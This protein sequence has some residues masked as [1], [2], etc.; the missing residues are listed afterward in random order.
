MTGGHPFP[1]PLDVVH[2]PVRYQIHTRTLGTSGEDYVGNVFRRED[3]LL[4]G[5]FGVAHVLVENE[6]EAEGA[7]FLVADNWDKKLT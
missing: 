6:I 7:L 1:F 4:K 5:G 3:S 2:H